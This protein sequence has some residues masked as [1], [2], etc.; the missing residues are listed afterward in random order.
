[1]DGDHDTPQLGSPELSL[2]VYQAYGGII[3]DIFAHDAPVEVALGCVDLFLLAEVISLLS[4]PRGER[5]EYHMT[6]SQWCRLFEEETA[7]SLAAEET[8]LAQS[9]VEF[10]GQHFSRK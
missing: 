5:T 2:S 1:M 7:C 10:F 8:C 3:D 6:T 9:G 4:Q